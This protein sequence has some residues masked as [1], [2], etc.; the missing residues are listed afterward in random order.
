MSDDIA[1][2]EFEAFV[3]KDEWP[4]LEPFTEDKE[5][6]GFI[7][8]GLTTLYAQPGNPKDYAQPSQS[9]PPIKPRITIEKIMPELLEK[10]KK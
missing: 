10:G 4:I 3:G 5:Y 7:D 2:I 8:L 9:W 1:K 6:G